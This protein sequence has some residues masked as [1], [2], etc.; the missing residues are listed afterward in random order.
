MI[1]RTVS[2]APRRLQTGEA[3]AKRVAQLQASAKLRAL[4]L[5]AALTQ[6]MRMM[7][8]QPDLRRLAF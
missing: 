5:D 8:A 1:R 6:V 7:Y 4:P 3:N 2:A